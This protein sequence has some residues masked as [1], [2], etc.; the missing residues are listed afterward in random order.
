MAFLTADTVFYPGADHS[1]KPILIT[2]RAIT[3][4]MA[5][6][7]LIRLFFTLMIERPGS[8]FDVVLGFCFGTVFGLGD[9]KP[10]QVD[11]SCLFDCPSNH[12]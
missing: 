7:T 5:R 8:V 10:F 6:T 1:R 11:K 4:H 3:R 2:F 9:Y 12:I